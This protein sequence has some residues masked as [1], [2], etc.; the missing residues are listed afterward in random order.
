MKFGS[1]ADQLVNVISDVTFIVPLAI[2]I[3]IVDTKCVTVKPE[4]RLSTVIFHFTPILCCLF[5][6]LTEI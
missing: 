1:F 3:S 2:E 4:E 5:E 6:N